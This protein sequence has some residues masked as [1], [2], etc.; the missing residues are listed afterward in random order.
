MGP[1]SCTPPPQLA[2]DENDEKQEKRPG[3]VLLHHKAKLR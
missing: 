3:S 1:Q 2:G